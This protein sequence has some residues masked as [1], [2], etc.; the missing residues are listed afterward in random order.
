MHAHELYEFRMIL[1]YAKR[2]FLS[3]Y[4][5]YTSSPRVKLI[6]Q[7]GTFL[8]VSCYGEISVVTAMLC[9]LRV[10]APRRQMQA[11][12]T[13]WQAQASLKGAGNDLLSVLGQSK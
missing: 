6:S 8:A 12:P 11:Y 7:L 4:A 3:D 13:Y 1:I 10:P 2:S 5:V 9:Q